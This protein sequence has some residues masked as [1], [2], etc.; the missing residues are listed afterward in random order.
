MAI[1]AFGATSADDLAVKLMTEENLSVLLTTGTVRSAAENITFGSMS[2]LAE[3]D[4]S[5]VIVFAGRIN[6]IKPIEFALRG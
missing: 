6:L 1:N 5:N 4:I 3:L 2:S